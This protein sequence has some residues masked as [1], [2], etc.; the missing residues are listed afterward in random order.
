MRD[1]I[2]QIIREA[3][4]PYIDRISELETEVDDLHRRSRNQGRRGVIEEVDYEKGLCKVRHGENL[5]HWIRWFSRSMGDIREWRPPTIGEG[6][7]LINYGGGNGGAQSIAITGVPTKEFPHLSD[8]ET[9]HR[10]EYPDEAA[11][12]YDFD[13]HK[14]K[15][16]NEQTSITHDR[17]SIE[18][19][20]G[21]NGIRIDASGVHVIGSRLDHNSINVGDNHFHIANGPTSGPNI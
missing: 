3:L 15:W 5:T 11:W 17:E 10:L 1:L 9:L 4:A 19:M 12:E 18:L 14:Y 2:E 20:H 13:T 16:T 8:V 7:V 21:E 6:C